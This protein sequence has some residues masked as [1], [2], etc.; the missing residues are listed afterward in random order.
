MGCNSNNDGM[1]SLGEPAEGSLSLY[2]NPKKNRCQNTFDY[3]Y[4]FQSKK[5]KTTKTTRKKIMTLDDGCLGSC[6]DEERSEMRNVMRSAMFVNHQ[7]FER[8][9]RSRLARE[10][11]CLSVCFPH[12]N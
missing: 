11:F 3:L 8:I 12:S 2:P 5:N 9:L 7:I 4:F 10:P 6:H 1:H